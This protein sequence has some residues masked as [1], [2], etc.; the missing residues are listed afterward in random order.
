MKKKRNLPPAA[1]QNDDQE[2]WGNFL[3]CVVSFLLRQ[4]SKPR[5]AFGKGQQSAHPSG[6]TESSPLAQRVNSRK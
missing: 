6:F 4:R 1:G 5:Y 2:V 3:A